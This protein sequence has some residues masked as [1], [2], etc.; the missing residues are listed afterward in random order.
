M[1]WHTRIFVYGLLVWR[2][3]GSGV[4][5]REVEAQN[6]DDLRLMLSVMATLR[7]SVFHVAAVFCALW[8][9]TL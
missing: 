1:R 9:H 5:G 2:V 8:R 6:A 7:P 3:G 4:G